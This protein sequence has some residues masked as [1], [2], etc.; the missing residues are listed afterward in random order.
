MEQT[1]T[2]WAAE[3]NDGFGGKTYS[4]PVVILCRWQNV[5]QLF[6]SVEGQEVVSEAVVYPDRELSISGKLVLGE[7]LSAIP[8]NEAKE[9]RQVSSSPDLSETEVLHKV[10]L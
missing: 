1:A 7:D 9:I 5:S 3:D 4:A 10:F 2:Y 6:R 8:P